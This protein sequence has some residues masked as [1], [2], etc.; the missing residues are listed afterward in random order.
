MKRWAYHTPETKEIERSL[1]ELPPRLIRL[2]ANRGLTEVEDINAF[3]RASYDEHSHD[4]ACFRDMGKATERIVRAITQREPMLLY[5]DYDVDGVSALAVLARTLRAL[6]HTQHTVYIPDRYTEGYGLQSEVLNEFRKKG[7]R[8]CIAC[9][10]GT[11]NVP[12][13]TQANEQGM[14]VI[15]VDHHAATGALPPAY[16]ILNPV[17]AGESYP[18]QRLCSTGVAFKLAQ[19]LLRARAYQ[20]LD[21][22]RLPHGWEKWLVDLVALAT[23]ADMVPLVGENRVFVKHGIRVM[24]KT[25]HIGLR[26]LLSVM[27]VTPDHITT[28]TI[29][30]HIAP[31]LNAAGRLKHANLAFLLLTTTDAHDARR[32]AEELHRMN[33]ERQQLTDRVLREAIDVTKTSEPRNIVVT[34]GEGWPSGVIG[35][36]A[37]RLKDIYHR[38]VLA[39]GIDHDT[40]VGSGR[41]IPGFDITRAITEASASLEKFGG[42]PM[43]CGF[44]VR[45]REELLEFFDQM[46]AIADREL[47]T[48][49]FTP[50]ISIDEELRLE[51]VSWELEGILEQ[52]EP[53]GVGVPQPIFTTKNLRVLSAEL[54]GQEGKHLRLRFANAE[55]VAGRAIGFGFGEWFLR[56]SP[57]DRVDVAYRVSAREWNGTR[58]LQC[59][60]VDIQPH[61]S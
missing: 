38:P 20:T 19:S 14:D 55:H 42:H 40:I 56:L 37:G 8:V 51:E 59:V 49:D 53:F 25:K 45:S 4:P 30:F 28:T 57:G 60:L 35:L 23:V 46:T 16:A 54:V 48:H 58:E 7:V 31:R 41:S 13:I 17:L 2:L 47:A 27:R 32:Y 18:F 22:A 11:T 3:L 43:A 10:C 39:V 15:L 1:P 36:V 9:D 61:A 12:E 33:S 29:G 34:Y 44:T 50:E 26:A 52:M 21:G 24:K 6:G 5:G